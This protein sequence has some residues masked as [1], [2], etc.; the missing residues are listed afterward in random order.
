MLILHIWYF[1]YIGVGEREKD[2]GTG[3]QGVYN[4]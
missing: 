4:R 2:S 3:T 1:D